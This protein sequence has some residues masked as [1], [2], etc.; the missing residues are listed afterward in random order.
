MPL[1]YRHHY[2]VCPRFISQPGQVCRRQRPFIAGSIQGPVIGIAE[3]L[4]HFPIH[5]GCGFAAV[6]AE[7]GR[8]EKHRA[9]IV[10]IP[11]FRF[12][13]SV[14]DASARRP[15]DRARKKK[16]KKQ[17]VFSWKPPLAFSRRRVYTM[18]KVHRVV[19]SLWGPSVTQ[20]QRVVV[21]QYIMAPKAPYFISG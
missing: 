10:K 19:V 8:Q 12:I 3:N 14:S 18:H 4:L 20:V 1:N 21:L 5:I 17:S 7:P 16:V 2:Y 11:H 13:S 9:G 6:P 15:R